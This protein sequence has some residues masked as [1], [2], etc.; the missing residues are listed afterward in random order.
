M[1]RASWHSVNAATSFAASP[2]NG[3]A[4]SDSSTTADNTDDD[5]LQPNRRRRRRE[6]LTD[7]ATTGQGENTTAVAATPP[8]PQ[9][10][11]ASLGGTQLPHLLPGV[12]ELQ[13]MAVSLA[14][15]SSW[16]PPQHFKVSAP[17]KGRLRG[18]LLNE[19]PLKL[20]GLADKRQ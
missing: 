18:L 15:N 8:Q 1:T 14:G 4:K 5:P 6:S 9:S 3:E 17:P 13:V 11:N 12:Y 2:T 7:E 16:T 19:N 20:Y 10:L